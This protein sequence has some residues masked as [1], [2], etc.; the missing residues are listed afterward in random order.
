MWSPIGRSGWPTSAGSALD[1]EAQAAILGRLE[2]FRVDPSDPESW[3]NEEDRLAKL[4]LYGK[5]K[6]V[7]LIR[8]P[9]WRPDVDGEAD[10]VEEIARIHGFEHVPSTP[11][12]REPGV[13]KPTATRAQ[14]IEHRV[15][16]TAAARGLDEAVTWSFIS[17]DEAA[18]FGGGDWRLQNPISE[19]MKV[20]RPSLL[21]S[22]IAA[23][24]RN[25]DRGQ[26]SLRLFEVG[27]R[28]L[29]D[30]EHRRSRWSSPGRSK[31]ATGRPA[32]RRVSTR[33]TPRPKRWPCSMRRALRSPASSCSPMPGQP[34]T[35]AGRRPCG[36]GRRRCSRRSASCIHA[37]LEA[38]DAPA[39]AVAAE[40][41]LDA[42]PAARDS[43]RARPAF[44]PPALQP[45]TRDFAFLVPPDLTADA[46]VRAIRGADKA[47]ITSARLFDRFETKEGLSAWRWKSRSS[48][49]DK[50]FTDEEIAAISKQIVAAAG[51]L[52]A[53]LRS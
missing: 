33:S 50:S 47:A 36:W 39:G 12:D 5:R 19:E 42:V 24:R 7:W 15:R 46:L 16:R 11:L 28:Y 30:A 48:P 44:A 31:H 22:L 32:R 9:T 17:E 6:D 20:M 53:Q 1:Q 21:P 18:P 35:R 49:T 41:Y 29:G 34:G 38:L 45:V 43:G 3:L 13:A 23:A 40:I 4:A 26:A 52:G 27:R 37:W 8:A 51:K 10:I 14:R 25:M 2:F